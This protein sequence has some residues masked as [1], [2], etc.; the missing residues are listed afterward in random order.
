[1]YTEIVS[2]ILGYFFFLIFVYGLF[3]RLLTENLLE[4]EETLERKK[5][6]NKKRKKYQTAGTERIK[7][8]KNSDSVE[9]GSTEQNGRANEVQESTKRNPKKK[10]SKKETKPPV[11]EVDIET[12]NNPE[13]GNSLK[14]GGF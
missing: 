12:E 13:Q 9:N 6:R 5:L 1:M 4:N 11:D 14:R 7:R 8:D 3:L 2:L 10:K